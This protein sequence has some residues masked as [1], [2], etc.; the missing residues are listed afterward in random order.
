MEIGCP[1]CGRTLRLAE[2][3]AGKQI[4]CPACQQIS[5]AP[6]KAENAEAAVGAD[7]TRGV[8]TTTS[9]HLR[10]PEG[11]I[12]GPIG[13]DEILAWVGEG[14]ITC[15]GEL[16]ETRSGPWRRVADILPA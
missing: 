6:G 10:M 3:H 16:A 1:T 15:D 13:W 2:E 14:R 5:I 9:W 11:P 12:Y 4:R 7:G 8:L